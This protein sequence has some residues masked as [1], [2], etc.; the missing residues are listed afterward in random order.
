M[1]ASVEI[2]FHAPEGVS[3]W[4][5]TLLRDP[6]CNCKPN[7]LSIKALAPTEQ[8]ARDLLH[9]TAFRI[10]TALSDFAGVSR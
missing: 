5:A 3:L 7:K 1:H 10:R 2:E 9:L 8:E 4:L 6:D